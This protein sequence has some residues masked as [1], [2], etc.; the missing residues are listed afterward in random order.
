MLTATGDGLNTRAQHEASTGEERG[1]I[2]A[3]S[4]EM[5]TSAALLL[6]ENSA[7]STTLM[8]HM[9]LQSEK[10]HCPSA[11]RSAD[12]MCFMVSPRDLGVML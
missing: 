8:C 5:L 11:N 7:L 3:E 4:R 1:R 12:C 10:C 6:S 2:S 9:M